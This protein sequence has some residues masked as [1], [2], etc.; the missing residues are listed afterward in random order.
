LENQRRRLNNGHT[1]GSKSLQEKFM[2]ALEMEGYERMRTEDI[3]EITDC[4]RAS[5]RTHGGL[6][7][8]SAEF[9]VA[10]F[11]YFPAYSY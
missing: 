8:F 2:S 7:G 9:G 3:L 4:G 1:L 6:L 10:P 5:E 11:N